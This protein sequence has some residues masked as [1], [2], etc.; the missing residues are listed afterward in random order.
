MAVEPNATDPFIA[1]QMQAVSVISTQIIAAGRP[2]G[3]HI[4]DAISLLERV[5][6]QVIAMSGSAAEDDATLASFMDG[7]SERITSLRTAGQ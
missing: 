4:K 1:M 6:A 7:V 3:G 2:P 5:A